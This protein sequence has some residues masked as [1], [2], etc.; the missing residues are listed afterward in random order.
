MKAANDEELFDALATLHSFHDRFRFF[1]GGLKTWRQVFPKANDPARARESLAYL[2]F[3]PGD[4]VE[5]MSNL[6]YEPRYKLDEFGQSNVQELIGWCNREDL[7]VL[8]GRTTKILRF[9]G[10]KVRQVQ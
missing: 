9:F 10:S 3:G 7:P 2:V 4:V 8:N 1:A 5:R 6:I